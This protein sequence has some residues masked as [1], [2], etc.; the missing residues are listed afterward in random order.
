MLDG[1]AEGGVESSGQNGPRDGA[2]QKQLAGL[3]CSGQVVLPQKH[4]VAENRMKTGGGG[5]E[6]L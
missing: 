1:E 3:L 6:V 4:K 5:P 2:G